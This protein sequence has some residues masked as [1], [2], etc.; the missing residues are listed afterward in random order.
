MATVKERPRRDGSSAWAVLYR[1]GKRQSSRSFETERAA[2]RFRVMVDEFGAERALAYLED[3][4]LAPEGI[5]VDDLAGAWLASKVGQVTP[6][7]LV[8]YERDY[9]G[10]IGPRLGHR[11]AAHVNEVDV[12]AWVDW[13]RLH[14]SPTTGKPLSPKSIADRHA[15]LH[16]MYAWGSARTRNVVPH[17]PCK[18][19]EL[20]PRVKSSPKGLRVPELYRLLEAGER[21]DPDAADLVA[22]MSGT[23]WRISECVALL[24]G[25]VEDDG[26]NVYV[27]MERVL[28][29]R[30]GVVE[31]G[32][33]SAAMR[34]L[35]VL[36]PAVPMLRR[37]L[38]GLG[39][40]DFVFTF[41]DG[42]PGVN[43]RGPWNVNSF[44]GIRWPRIV[45]AAGL[46]ERKPTPHWLRHTHVALC[47]AAGLSL[48]EIQRRLGH[49][50]I[51]TTINIYGRMIEDMS[52]DSAARL[53]ALLTPT[54]PQLVQ[55]D[56]VPGE[57]TPPGSA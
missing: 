1:H 55:G 20:P 28:R 40:G 33:S 32:K 8:G 16:Q 35:R 12:Q 54:A 23:G 11:E 13:M 29:R 39:P 53:D 46:A 22:F 37:R 45:A 56:V 7:I 48:A 47:H 24:A 42:R 50:D 30:V 4:S 15:I 2:E 44:R 10:W 14:P 38:V 26:V 3:E 52:D 9:A 6:N 18:E 41:A 19:T 5:T 51:Q 49:E 27:T 17:N 21:I 57:L 36:G 31:G 43:R 25:A 34:R